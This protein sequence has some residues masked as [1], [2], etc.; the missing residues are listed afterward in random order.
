MF[1]DVALREKLAANKMQCSS[2]QLHVCVRL[3][4]LSCLLRITYAQLVKTGQITA[5]EKSQL[6]VVQQGSILAAFYAK[7]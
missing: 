4:P 6:T 3:V 5:G 2:S 1:N 7:L